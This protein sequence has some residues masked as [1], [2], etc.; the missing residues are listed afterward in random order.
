MWHGNVGDEIFHLAFLTQV[1]QS[2]P[3]YDFYY[4]GLPAFYPPLYFWLTG[5]LGKFFVHTAV[6]ATK[7]GITLTFFCW[8]VGIFLWCALYKK[9]LAKKDDASV[10]FSPWFWLAAS[11][12]TFCLL[13]VEDF[14]FKPYEVLSALG[15]VLFVVFVAKG[16]QEKNW[17]LKQYIF[18]GVSGGLLFL[19]YYFWWFIA[20]PALFIL[21]FLSEEKKKNTLR[22]IGFGVVM[23][24][25]ASPYL[26]P[27]VYSFRHGIENWQSAYL[28]PEYLYTFLPY[29]TFG[30][31]PLGIIVGMCGMY[32]YRKHATI[33]ATLGIALVGYGYQLVNLIFFLCGFKPAIPNKPFDFLVTS[34]FGVAA[35]YTLVMV[36]QTYVSKRST[37]W[38]R[39][40]VIACVILSLPFWPMTGFMDRKETLEK[41]DALR[42]T[43]PAS[44][45]ARDIARTVPDYA[46]R[47]W[48][49]SGIPDINA[50]IPLHYVI[51]YNPHFSHYAA[52]YSERLEK[53]TELTMLDEQKFSERIRE[54][55]ID[56]MLLYTD[57][58]TSTYPLF[59]WADHYPN[60][61][62][63]YELDI[64]KKN[65]QALRWKEVF[66]GYGWVIL[67]KEK[68]G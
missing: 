13:H 16:F 37:E 26:V 38:R 15:V 31:R 40:F 35:A 47:T 25:V 48:L 5:F 9:T 10:V 50:Y 34:A 68:E 44:V 33:R 23:F 18:F 12:V 2:N 45:L 42:T 36:W 7:L 1:M 28:I 29:V 67:I 60:G 11:A 46:N 27:L 17:S 49:T 41:L 52:K 20:I 8:F 53:V 63:E 56:A 14:L 62:R 51:A 6:G 19:T 59:F 39:G 43:P 4:H 64:A 61:G 54:L 57:A 21:A 3:F 66:R 65:V 30:F 32:A 22:V 24:L 55:S 58:S